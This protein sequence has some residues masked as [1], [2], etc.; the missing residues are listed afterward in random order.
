M[1]VIVDPLLQV[2]GEGVDYPP[3]W[4]DNDAFSH[5]SW[6]VLWLHRGNHKFVAFDDN[7]VWRVVCDLMVMLG[8]MFVGGIAGVEVYA[9]E[10][11]EDLATYYLG[12]VVGDREAYYGVAWELLGVP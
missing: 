7:V 9:Y 8:E 1:P 2:D 3:T 11:E 4:V 12:I 10:T 6:N 5:I